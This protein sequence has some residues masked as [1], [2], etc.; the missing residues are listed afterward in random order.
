M[1][2]TANEIFANLKEY[3]DCIEYPKYRNVDLAVFRQKYEALVSVKKHLETNMKYIRLVNAMSQIIAKLEEQKRFIE[4]PDE[5]IWSNLSERGM[6]KVIPP[7][8]KSKEISFPVEWL[9]KWGNACS[10]NHGYWTAKNYRVMDA[11]GYMFLLKE[12]GN[13]LPKEPCPIFNDL[14]EVSLRENQLSNGDSSEKP[15]TKYK[16]SFTDRDFRKLTALNMNSSDIL[17][18]LLETARVEFKLSFPV[19]LKSTGNREQLHRMNVYSRLFE[20]AEEPIKKRKDGVIQERRYQVFFSTILGELF[21]NNLKARFN[22]GITLKFYT[23]PD[24]AQIFYRRIFLHHSFNRREIYLE[25]IAKTVGLCD[26]NISNLTKTVERNVLE[27]LKSY[28]YI[29]SYEK[30]E[31]LN[32]IKYVLIRK[33]KEISRD[34]GSVK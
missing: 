10:V 1:D 3:Y 5:Q 14:G 23:L 2:S 6:N 16:I 24:S 4:M 20:L 29:E 9:D 15:S 31:G 26:S 17:A 30:T 25:E 18:L 8:C 13:A 27:P 11:L 34:G 7:V 21:V 12:G 32:G 28:G 19:R 22:D 33:S